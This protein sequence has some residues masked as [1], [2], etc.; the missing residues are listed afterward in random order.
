MFINRRRSRRVRHTAFRVRYS[1]QVDGLDVDDVFA[2]D[3]GNRCDETVGTG[4]NH[5][6][7]GTSTIPSNE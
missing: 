5:E 3:F 4:C 7:T 6:P 1:V 2:P